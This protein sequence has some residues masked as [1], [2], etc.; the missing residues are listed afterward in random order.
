MFV[1]GAEVTLPTR[2]WECQTH[3]Q[4]KPKALTKEVHENTLICINPRLNSR[5]EHHP[6]LHGT[7]KKA[8]VINNVRNHPPPSFD[9]DRDP[10]HFSQYDRDRRVEVQGPGLLV[11]STAKTQGYDCRIPVFS[12]QSW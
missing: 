5:P 1:D 11:S 10:S 9:R 2:V 3:N 8:V 7:Y 12:L 4:L 6:R